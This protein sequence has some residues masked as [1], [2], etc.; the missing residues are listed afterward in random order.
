MSLSGTK[1][2]TLGEQIQAYKERIKAHTFAHAMHETGFALTGK[3]TKA[4]CVDCHKVPLA[5][6][7]PPTVRQCVACHKTDDV[8]RGRR[9]QCANCHTTESWRER[10]R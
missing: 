7:R 8:H 9:P 3:H 4:E 6:A 2:R 5:D 10:K 1:P